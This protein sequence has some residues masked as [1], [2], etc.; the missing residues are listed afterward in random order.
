MADMLR[1]LLINR[2]DMIETEYRFQTGCPY[3]TGCL[4]LFAAESGIDDKMAK[5]NSPVR[6]DQGV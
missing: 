4:F 2:Q 3:K 6:I 1:I 5:K